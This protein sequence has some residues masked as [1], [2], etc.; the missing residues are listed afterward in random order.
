METY[1]GHRYVPKI[2]GVWNK[3]LTYENLSI[4]TY[5]NSSYTSKTIVPVGVDISN[6]KYWIKTGDYNAQ[7]EEFKN[8]FTAQLA[9]TK[10]NLNIRNSKKTLFFAH[11][12]AESLVPENTV[13][14]A[15][16]ACSLGFDGIE[17]D[18]QITSDKEWVMF[19]DDTLDLKTN[20]SGTVASKTLA[21]LKELTIEY[22]PYISDRNKGMK[23]ATLR[24]FLDVCNHWNKIPVLEIK[25]ANQE[26]LASL[27][28]VFKEYNITDKVYLSGNIYTLIYCRDNIN[29]TF[30]PFPLINPTIETLEIASTEFPYC[31]VAIAKEL[32]TQ[33]I[34]ELLHEKGLGC[35]IWTIGQSDYEL[36]DT[37]KALGV[38]AFI[39]GIIQ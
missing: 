28:E 9:Q 22:G 6:E 24:E 19:H 5:D 11:R 29:N 18:M 31:T 17:G 38:E 30:I 15:E 21:E 16:Y 2:M 35:A 27:F 10:S 25:Q 7:V 33:E 32:A 37:Y 20:G 34:V 13:L 8:D 3:L 36:V 23:I 39:G 12:G 26:D 1:V 4:V 14:S